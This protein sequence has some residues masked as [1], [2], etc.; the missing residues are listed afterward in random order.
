MTG[1]VTTTLQASIYPAYISGCMHIMPSL[2][3]NLGPT[4]GKYSKISNEGILK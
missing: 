2:C 4:A 1:V 3:A